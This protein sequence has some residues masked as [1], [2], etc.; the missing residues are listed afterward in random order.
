MLV[1]INNWFSYLVENFTYMYVIYLVIGILSV[2][3]LYV[4]VNI[5]LELNYKR[6]T[7]FNR[8]IFSF[9]KK[10]QYIKAFSVLRITKSD[11]LRFKQ[12]R[13]ILRSNYN[14]AIL[15]HAD[16]FYPDKSELKRRKKVRFREVITEIHELDYFSAIRDDVKLSSIIYRHDDGINRVTL[17]LGDIQGITNIISELIV[18]IISIVVRFAK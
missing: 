8:I 18:G 9:N 15:N 13:R 12:R 7:I 5:W 3:A 4:I 6:D 10:I 16:K 14:R 17:T 2:L 1:Y 11:R